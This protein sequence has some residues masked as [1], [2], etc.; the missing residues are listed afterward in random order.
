MNINEIISKSID[1]HMTNVYKKICKGDLIG[2]D[3]CPIP[4]ES[5]DNI[6]SYF[7][8]TEDYEMCAKILKKKKERLNHNNNFHRPS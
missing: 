7:E 5:Y 4:I 8:K 3:G 6:I 1:C 2:E